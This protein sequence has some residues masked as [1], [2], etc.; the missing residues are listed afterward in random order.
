MEKFDDNKFVD[1]STEIKTMNNKEKYPDK[2]IPISTAEEIEKIELNG[3]ADEYKSHFFSRLDLRFC[4]ILLF[5]FLAHVLLIYFLPRFLPSEINQRAIEKVQRKFV[6]FLSEEQLVFDKSK[7][8]ESEA[9][10][11]GTMDEKTAKNITKLIEDIVNGVLKGGT[12]IP[13]LLDYSDKLTTPEMIEK[14]VE[15]RLPTA[16][17]R[18]TKRAIDASARNKA[19]SDVSS[20]VSRVGLLGLITSGSGAVNYEYIADILESASKNS[21]DFEEVLGRLQALKIP[22]YDRKIFHDEVTEGL[23]TGR[24]AIRNQ[25]D[26]YEMVAPLANVEQTPVVRKTML[27]NDDNSLLAGLTRKKAV[28]GKAR[29]PKHLSQVVAGHNRAIQDCYKQVLKHQPGLKGKLTVRIVIN[30]AG[31]VVMAEILNSTLNNPKIE[32][33][34]LRRIRRWNNF[35]ACDPKLGNVPFIQVYRFGV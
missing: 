28:N 2:N 35:G 24:L 23:K 5:S 20:R 31:K 16:E 14:M 8:D 19:M 18:K 13:D 30:P 26:F 32:K 12:E 3:L 1:D 7:K 15:T 10:I 11:W 9:E 22:R 6:D 29:H 34:V 25:N 33:C 17:A 4:L 21:E 27:E